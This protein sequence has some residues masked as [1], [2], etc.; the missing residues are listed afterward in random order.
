MTSRDPPKTISPARPAVLS[1]T[2]STCK[3]NVTIGGKS[4][5]YIGLHNQVILSPVRFGSQVDLW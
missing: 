4:A 2:G 1:K 5:H 3:L